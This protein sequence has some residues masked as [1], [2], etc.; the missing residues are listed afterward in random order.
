MYRLNAATLLNFPEDDL[1]ALSKQ[2]LISMVSTLRAKLACVKQKVQKSLLIYR[3]NWH[4][5]DAELEKLTKANIN[6]TANQP[7]SK[8]AEFN[9]DTGTEPNKKKSKRKKKEKRQSRWRQS[10]KTRARCCK[11]KLTNDLP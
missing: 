5:R 8:Q 11:P 10:D 6:S 9:K 7:S 3:G 1:L 2:E 4:Q